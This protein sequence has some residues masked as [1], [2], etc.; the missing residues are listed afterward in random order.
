[1]AGWFKGPLDFDPSTSVFTLAPAV[2]DANFISSYDLSGN[3]IWASSIDVNSIQPFEEMF[4]KDSLIYI[5]GVLKTTTDFD[6]TTAVLNLSPVA[7]EDIFVAKYQH[8][9]CSSL[10]L[11]IDSVANAGCA[12][13]GLGIGHAYGGASPYGYLWNT[14]PVTNDSLALFSSSGI[15]D[16]S[17]TDTLGCVVQRT[18]IVNG[19]STTSNFDFA[20]NLVT[21][22]FQAGQLTNVWPNAVNAGCISTSGTLFLV[23]NPQV[24]F[25]SSIP[26]VDAINGDT[27]KWNTPVLNYDLP[28]FAPHVVL[29]ADT[30]VSSGD[31]ICLTVGIF[32][33]SGDYDPGNNVKNYCI[34]ATASY[35]PNDKKVYPQGV[36]SN[37]GILNNQKMTYTIRFQN[38]GTASAINIYLLDSLDISLALST[39]HVISSSHY[40]FTEVF[41]GNV[42]KFN[43]PNI[44]LPDSA[45]NEPNSHGYVIFEINQLPNLPHGTF[46]E[47]SVNIFFDYNPPVTTNT[48]FNTIDIAS[49][50][51]VS[52]NN[53]CAGDST[54]LTAVPNVPELNANWQWFS[55]SCSGALLGSGN[56]IILN[57]NTST[58]YYLFDSINGWCTDTLIFV[59]NVNVGVSQTGNTL[60]ANANSAT[61]QWLNC[62]TVFAPINGETNQNFVATSNGNYAVIVTENGCSDTSTCFT[63]T[64]IGLTNSFIQNGISVYPNPTN[65]VLNVS[66]IGQTVTCY[67]TDL[68]EK[69]VMQKQA[70]QSGNFAFDISALSKGVYYLHISS[71]ETN[72]AIKI[73]KQ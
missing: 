46:I 63:I 19:P 20:A 13:N 10:N 9:L 60:T 29:A 52:N 6:P 12:F 27:L 42:L 66:N 71:T 31:T 26:S 55:V 64:G 73:V 4:V 15:Y 70:V 7:I 49:T 40:M 17:V 62:D 44:Y 45:S 33:M 67:I 11:I 65:N 48:V 8:G 22:N 28:A 57:P 43:F 58:T 38:T 41:P 32:P 25:V 54:L 69:I 21:T 2:S 72:Y 24:S 23:L 16:I 50:I 53:I 5:T 47:N 30:S 68:A 59:N 34:E 35:D 14:S 37:H 56:S 61:Y 1:M 18:A 36:S 51:L 39:V 3:F